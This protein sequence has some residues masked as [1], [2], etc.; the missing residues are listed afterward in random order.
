MSDA[1]RIWS[2]NY[3]LLMSV[4]SGAEPG[5]CALNLES[6]ELFVLAEIDDHPYPAELAAAFCMPKATITSYLKRLEAAGY[7]RREIDPSDLRRHRL[8]LTREG[9]RV[10][11]DGLAMLSGEFDKR[12]SRITA[13]QRKEFKDLLERIV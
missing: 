6:K 8:E 13:A 2:L 4:I 10:A 7:V 3:R 1:A 9:R 5:I 11:A 12:L